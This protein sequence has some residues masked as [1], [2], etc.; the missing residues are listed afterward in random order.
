MTS[1]VRCFYAPRRLVATHVAS[2][3]GLGHKL[4]NKFGNLCPS[5]FTLANVRQLVAELVRQHV[6]SVKALLR[7]RIDTHTRTES[8]TPLITYP[9][10]RLC[11]PQEECL[12]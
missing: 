2:V 6:A 10:R 3:K 8:Q 7:A 1:S 4:S 12:E 11:R 5:P 9:R